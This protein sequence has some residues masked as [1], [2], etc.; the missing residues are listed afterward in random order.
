[1]GNNKVNITASD[2]R[3]ITGTL[4]NYA[5]L[6]GELNAYEANLKLK[7]Q[8]EQEYRAKAVAEQKKKEEAKEKALAEINSAIGFVNEAKQRYEASNSDSLYFVMQEGKLTVKTYST[9]SNGLL[10]EFFDMF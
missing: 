7:K 3:V 6:V 1:M 5:A 8:K 2:G 10:K 4:D 9:L